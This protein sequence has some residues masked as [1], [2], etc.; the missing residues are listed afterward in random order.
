MVITNNFIEIVNSSFKKKTE[1]NDCFKQLE[2]SVGHLAKTACAC[3]NTGKC[4]S[5]QAVWR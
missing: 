1:D 3:L 5:S 2:T 4:C